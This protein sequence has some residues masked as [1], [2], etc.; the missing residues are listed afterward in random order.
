MTAF[1]FL[2]RSFYTF[3][4]NL[5]SQCDF[6]KDILTFLTLL[7]IVATAFNIIFGFVRR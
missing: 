3:L 5:I 4:I 1:Y 6:F 2:L 7:I